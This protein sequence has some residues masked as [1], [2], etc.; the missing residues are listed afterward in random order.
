MTH[1]DDDFTIP[2]LRAPRAVRVVAAT[3]RRRLARGSARHDRLRVIAVDG[4]ARVRRLLELAL[5]W[6]DVVTTA[7]ADDARSLLEV[8]ACDLLV[9]GD[10][11]LLAHAEVFHPEVQRVLYVVGAPVEPLS[12]DAAAVAQHRIDRAETWQLLQLC[13][14]LDGGRPR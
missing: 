4:D 5:R 14:R 8:S 10:F 2:P 1:A 12:I 9:T 3:P 7:S 6:Y 13:A 11:E